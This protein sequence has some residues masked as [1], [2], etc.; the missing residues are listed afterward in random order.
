[1]WKEAAYPGGSPLGALLTSAT[2][3]VTFSN[4]DAPTRYVI[5]VSAVAGDPPITSRIV[6]L[7]ASETLTVGIA[8]P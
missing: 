1:I 8:V 5:E 3:A 6:S 4:L 7:G 2:G